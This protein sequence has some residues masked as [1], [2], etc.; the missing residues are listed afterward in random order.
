MHTEDDYLGN[1]RRHHCDMLLFQMGFDNM[2]A[3]RLDNESA[4]LGE[5]THTKPI[6]APSIVQVV[7]GNG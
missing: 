7:V 6:E 4:Q 1:L 3:V 5:T 2:P